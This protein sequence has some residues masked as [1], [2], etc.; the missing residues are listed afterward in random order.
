MTSQH[1]PQ[2]KEYQGNFSEPGLWTKISRVAQKAGIKVIYLALLFFYVLKSGTTAKKDRSI[3]LGALGYFI[4][5]ID[6]IPDALPVVG[7]SDD[8]AALVAVYV[9]MRHS[10]TPEIEMQARARLQKWFPQFTESDLDIQG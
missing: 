9:A 4:L 3:I 7:F 6:L 5:P 10:I 1:F 2:L 8:L